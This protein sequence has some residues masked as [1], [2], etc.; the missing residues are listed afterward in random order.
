MRGIGVRLI[1]LVALADGNTIA[2]STLNRGSDPVVMLGSDLPT[3]NGL[4]VNL[5]VGFRYDGGWQQIPIQI[6]ERKVVDFGTVYNDGTYGFT[7]LSYT[8][9]NTYTGPDTNPAFDADDELVFM[10]RNAA[11]RA[12]PGCGEPAGVVPGTGI[13]IRIT[14]PIDGGTG[15]VYLFRTDGS[16]APDA[17]QD[18]VTYTFNLLAGPYIPNYKTSKGPN[19][20]NSVMVSPYYRTHFSDRWICDELNVYAGGA[21]GIDILDRHK[22]MFAPGN[23][24][25]TEDTFSNGEGAFF[26]NKDGPVRA[27]RSYMG[28]NSG[29]LTQRTHLFYE[30]RQDVRTDLRVHVIYG[31]MDLYDYTPAAAGMTYYNDQ[32][33]GGLLIDGNPDSPNA[34]QFV[35]EMVTGAQGSVVISHARDTDISPVQYFCYYS[36]DTTPTYTQCTG[37]AYEYG[38]SGVWITSLIPNTDP[39]MGTPCYRLAAI[40][41]VYYEGPSQPLATATLRRLQATTALSL[42][43][44]TYQPTNTLTLSYVN[45]AFGTVQLDPEPSDPNVPAYAPNTAVTLTAMPNEGRGLRHWELYDPNHPGDANYA[46]IDANNPIV[47]VMNANREVTAVFKCGSG[48]AGA[49]LIAAAVPGLFWTFRRIRTR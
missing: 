19:P 7:T 48:M 23:C 46:V 43:A 8:D 24:Q 3:F 16:L 21:T 28:A 33:T 39:L 20:E 41:I 22:N 2:A 45:G 4:A 31:M 49:I 10:A 36:D 38:T 1:V 27:L 34:S 12:G 17:G 25:R 18:Y 11:D 42:S 44:S 47:L 14:D 9:P 37:D 35:W 40:R 13:E 6:D 32:N 29:P 26:V 30:Q 5:V 15:Y